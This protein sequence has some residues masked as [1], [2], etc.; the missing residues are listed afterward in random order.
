M[1]LATF[2]AGCFWC[3]EPCFKA[4]N[5]VIS[6]VS[7][8]TGGHTENPTYKEICQGD[9]G[10]AEV[11]QITYDENLVSFDELLEVFWFVHDPTQLNRQGNDV[12]TQYRSAIF[13]HTNEQKNRA[14]AYKEKLNLSQVWDK[15]VVTE[16]VPLTTFYPAENYHQDYLEFNPENAYCQ[17]IVRPKV[18]KFR[19]VFAHKLA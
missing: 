16:I 4:L 11:V 12:G 15:P 8:Y 17:A 7:G 10:H 6:A 1:A 14:E 19:K 18:D 5:G 13:Y 9:T 2:G 3:V